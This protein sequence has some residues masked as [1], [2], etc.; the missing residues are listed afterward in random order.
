MRSSHDGAHL[1]ER[2]QLPEMQAVPEHHAPVGPGVDRLASFKLAEDVQ[3]SP[4]ESVSCDRRVE[5][6][7][8]YI[9]GQAQEYF[10]GQ[11][12]WSRQIAEVRSEYTRKVEKVK[13]EKV[14][15]EKQARQEILRLQRCLRDLGAS[16]EVVVGRD[17]EH[18]GDDPLARRGSWAVGVDMEDHVN[19]QRQLAAAEDRIRCLEQY[20]KDQS[21]KQILSIGAQVQETEEIQ[22]LRQIVIANNAELGLANS[23]LQA[24]RAQH[25]QRTVFWDQGVRRVLSTVEPF[26][27]GQG[28]RRE[29]HRLERN[30]EIEEQLE[31]GNF[32]R[33]ATKLSFTLSQG[34]EG[35][36]NSLRR[37]LKDVL[38]NG[39]DRSGQSTRR[40]P[41]RPAKDPTSSSET[42][43]TA[44]GKSDEPRKSEQG[45]LEE[46]PS[47]SN[48]S[49]RDTSPGSAPLRACC[50]DRGGQGA[51]L[52]GVAE[53]LLAQL[54]FDLRNLLA[55]SQQQDHCGVS[56]RASPNNS[57]RLHDSSG[58]SKVEADARNQQLMDSIA[59]ARKGITQ[60]IISVEKLI[61]GLDRD[62]R[63]C[64]EELLGRGGLSEAQL[65][66][67]EE[68]H[69]H[70]PLGAEAQLL[71]MM[72]LQKAQR[73]S[74]AALVE[75]VQLPQKLKAIFD[76]TKHL[77]NE[78]EKLAEAETQASVARS[79]EQRRA[80][81]VEILHKQVQALAIQASSVTGSPSGGTPL[82]EASAAAPPVWRIPCQQAWGS[83]PGQTKGVEWPVATCAA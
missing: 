28:Q 79:S 53:R 47:D 8:Q 32:G 61:R 13:R 17:D 27:V 41:T 34:R 57:P 68:A 33:T 76:L 37:V 5:E 52:P 19:L 16:E 58:G 21:A 51:A 7:S 69:N 55:M 23:E 18:G 50:P 39:K 1:P 24:W 29:A 31:T 35:D 81:Q 49:S 4:K 36:V 54:A 70:V 77:I 80:M 42:Q 22:Q 78:I 26:L 67:E 6:L 64:C 20:I 15:L 75:F 3:A 45:K 48:A 63:G 73:Q 2:V 38:R 44:E 72:A 12:E 65:S 30:A 11:E 46:A 66:V 74:S 82:W 40:S 83:S 56:A 62:L 60:N 25:Q 71:A 14:E 43:E 10:E 59:A 9:R